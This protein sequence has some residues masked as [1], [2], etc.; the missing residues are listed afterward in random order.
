MGDTDRDQKR[1]DRVACVPGV[2]S[3]KLHTVV[4]T[5]V[6]CVLA[7]TRGVK[8]KSESVRCKRSVLVAWFIGQGCMCSLLP[9]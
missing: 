2:M 6:S 5:G 8:V 7:G 9:V 1:F 4:C 3:C